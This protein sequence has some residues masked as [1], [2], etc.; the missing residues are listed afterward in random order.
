[1]TLV[2]NNWAF[3]E[4]L[5][6]VLKKS[7]QGEAVIVYPRSSTQLYSTQ[8]VLSASW[9]SMRDIIEDLLDA[10][11]VVVTC[12]GDDGS[13]SNSDFN[14]VPAVWASQLPII[15]AGAVTNRGGF[16]RFSRGSRAEGAKD[17]IWALGDSV[18]CVRNGISRDPKD[19]QDRKGQ[20][21]SFSAGMVAHA[22]HFLLG[23]SRS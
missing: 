4:V 12:A 10:D 16:A 6:D 3:A 19:P 5:D 11:V 2:D 21:T 13:S 22:F 7:R 8:S 9:I 17:A 23:R 1:M 20:G 14:R 18:I 15:V